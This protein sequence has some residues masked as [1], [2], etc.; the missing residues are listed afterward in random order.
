MPIHRSRTGWSWSVTA[1]MTVIDSGIGLSETQQ[2]TLLEPP[3]RGPTAAPTTG[4]EGMGIAICQHLATGMGG[5]IGVDSEP[6]T[7]S[8]FWVEAPFGLPTEKELAGGGISGAGADGAHLT[9][10]TVLLVE[11]NKLNQVVAGTLLEK[12]RVNVVI[13][14]HGQEAVDA[15]L[16][17]RK[18]FDAVL[19]DLDMPVMDG[20]EATRIIREQVAAAELPIIALTANAV[21][22]DM[23]AC[24]DIG[25]NAYLTKPIN[26]R[27]LFDAVF[28][29]TRGARVADAS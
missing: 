9:G 11:D 8:R 25:M 22:T 16:R 1:R 4:V 17:E 29:A 28:K 23:Q 19:M 26:P 20:K 7:G 18:L 5:R 2:A 12:Q 24:L 10:L 3:A 15:I 13:A 6:G 21:A 27:D 14:N